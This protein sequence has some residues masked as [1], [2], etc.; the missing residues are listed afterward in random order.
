MFQFLNPI[1]FFSAAAIAIPVLI[2]LWN[3]RPGKVLKVGSISLI[4]AAS[5]KSSRSFKLLDVTLFILRCLLLL[6]IALLLAMPVWQKKVQAV[7]VKGWLL[8]PKE[9]LTETYKKFKRTIDS[10][11]RAGYEFHYFNTGFAKSNL[12]QI[13][14]HPKDSILASP[15]AAAAPLA[16]YW[17]LF[18]QLN[19]RVSSPLPVFVFT[20]NQAKYFR[21]NKPEIALNLHW[22]TYTPADSASSW[23]QD[24]WFT[25]AGDIRVIQG[26]S[27]PLGTAYTYSTVSATR[28]NPAFSIQTAG[29]NAQVK[30]A[31]NNQA[32]FNIDTTT[33]RLLIYADNSTDAAYL[34]AALQAVSSFTQRKT[35]LRIITN[36]GQI[37][38][39]TQW[40]FWLSDKTLNHRAI[41]SCN[42]IFA[43]Q[44]GKIL[45]VNTL[46]S[47]AGYFSTALPDEGKVQLFKAVSGDSPDPS[48]WR[49]GFGKPILSAQQYGKTSIYR[50]YS[51]F[52]PAWNNLVWSNAFPT[53]LLQLMQAS[54][55]AN[56]PN[57]DKRI[58]SR[59]QYMP[60]ITSA[61][62][63]IAA[64]KP[65]ENKSLGR[66]FWLALVIVFAAERWLAHR[67]PQTHNA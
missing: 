59:Q 61:T 47:N 31:N 27:T 7:K 29:D 34:K 14:L 37:S 2:H 65:A 9:N 4:N 51:R 44:K 17:S 19:N 24:A 58:L 12:K 66:Y 35:V 36:P 22:Q 25:N 5:R 56:Q 16:N 28:S 38:P 26:N 57:S 3:I 41:K 48:I 6:L 10:L 23:I 55:Q 45:N 62:H 67:T 8:V 15:P 39:Q 46:M 49:D 33:H 13:L 50:F 32:P 11:N 64:G 60:V 42:H 1:W 52:N 54:H 40:L 18:K 53:W 21:G 63:T 20:P 30:P 43:Y